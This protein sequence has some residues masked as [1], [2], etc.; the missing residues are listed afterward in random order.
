MKRA[1]LKSVIFVFSFFMLLSLGWFV[2]GVMGDV[3][4]VQTLFWPSTEGTVISGEMATVH[5]SKGASK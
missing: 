5:S 4:A 2:F 1:S 3:K